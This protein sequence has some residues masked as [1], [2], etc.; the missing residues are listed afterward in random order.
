MYSDGRI[1]SAENAT[2]DGMATSALHNVNFTVDASTASSLAISPLYASVPHLA[3]SSNLSRLPAGAALPPVVA[4]PLVV[5]SSRRR[6]RQ[7][8]VA[9]A[10]GA[11]SPELSLR[12]LPRRARRRRNTM[13]APMRC[14][15]FIA[16]P[17]MECSMRNDGIPHAGGAGDRRRTIVTRAA[18][19]HAPL[20][21][22][23]SS[24]R[25]DG[26]NGWAALHQEIGE[27]PGS[28]RSKARPL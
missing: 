8:V 9:A 27:L 23:A 21:T 3:D 20:F 4:A 24:R 16:F 10:R 19:A 7:P 12:T 11:S 13:S 22:R 17:L 18:H 2:F 6:R 1:C 15:R 28:A 5:A 25:L 26:A 14:D